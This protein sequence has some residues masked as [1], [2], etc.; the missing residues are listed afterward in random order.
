MSEL[1][2]GQVSPR[3]ASAVGEAHAAAE[4]ARGEDPL[5][6]H[7][8]RLLVLE[9]FVAAAYRAVDDLLARDPDRGQLQQFRDDHER[10]ALALLRCVKR[11]APSLSIVDDPDATAA[12]TSEGV[13]DGLTPFTAMWLN[14]EQVADA[15]EE[16]LSSTI[17][18][19]HVRQALVR[20]LEDALQHWSWLTLHVQP[21]A[22]S[23]H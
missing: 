1:Y 9:T 14:E 11:V 12:T 3:A 6:R 16:L 4:T 8:T 19:S 20:G 21:H 13:V 18:D 15:Y 5:A 10:N 17:D 2:E 23:Q 22:R 7:L